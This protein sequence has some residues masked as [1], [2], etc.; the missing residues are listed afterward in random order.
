MYFYELVHF[1]FIHTLWITLLLISSLQS[2]P[3]LIPARP[4]S[5]KKNV[6]N[7]HIYDKDTV[8]IQFNS[9]SLSVLINNTTSFYMFS[10]T[11]R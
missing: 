8:Y 10:S 7:V 11:V 2:Y 3:T 9:Y 1:H 4:P 6:G 5:E